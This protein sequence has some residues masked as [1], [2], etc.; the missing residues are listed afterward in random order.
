MNIMQENEKYVIIGC[1]GHARSVADVILYN[2]PN[3]NIIFLD[4]KARQDESILGFPVLS[5]YK[6][7]KEKVI[8]AIGDN[9]KRVEL[10]EK[11]YNNLTNVIS[12][13]AYIGK[14]VQLGRG[15]FAGHNA[16]I[17]VLSTISDFCIINTS[18]I[19]EHECHIGQ[20]A[21]IAPN[22]TLLG[23]VSIDERSFIGAGTT[24]IDNIKSC[25]DVIIGA[26]S[27]VIND[28]E[29]SGTYVGNKLRRI[30]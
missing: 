21:F 13:L 25:A 24:V 5:E 1:G 20:G 14:N 29:Q 11:Y 30:K 9:K 4:E 23:K 17:G 16:Y 22:T 26:Q 6:I 2:N 3:S 19:V 27:I 7:T 28:I 8:V 18:A 12:K 10:S 15:I